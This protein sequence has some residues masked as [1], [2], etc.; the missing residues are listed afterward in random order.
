MWIVKNERSEALSLPELQIDIGIKEYVDLDAHGRA[1]AEEARSVRAAIEKGALR[2]I[3]KSPVAEAFPRAAA[4]EPA[5]VLK[6]LV[7][8]PPKPGPKGL[9]LPPSAGE[10]RPEEPGVNVRESFRR[11]ARGGRRA[12]EAEEPVATPEM[13]AIRKELEAFRRKLLADIERLLDSRL[14]PG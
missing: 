10:E 3:S 6:D 8:N 12:A 14:G 2:V 5:G 4:A 13:A 11:M 1:R 7:E 9:L